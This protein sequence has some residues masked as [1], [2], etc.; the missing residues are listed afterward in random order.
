M[1]ADGIVPG[2]LEEAPS[3][4]IAI[5]YPNGKEVHIGQE[6]TPTEVK[7]EPKVKWEGDPN[8]FYTLVMFDP[9]APSREDPKVA[10]VKHWLVCTCEML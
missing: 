3:A 9:D 10:D 1:E 6:L 7:D 4:E 5:T 2:T 8:K